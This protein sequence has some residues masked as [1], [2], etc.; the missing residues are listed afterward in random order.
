MALTEQAQASELTVSIDLGNEA[1]LTPAQVANA[2]SLSLLR[3]SGSA[4]DPI[5]VG[6]TGRIEDENGN[7]VGSWEAK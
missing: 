5:E 4:F 6:M 1:M 3:Y 7:L 2:L